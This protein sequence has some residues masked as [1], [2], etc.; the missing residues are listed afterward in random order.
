MLVKLL[1]Y[2]EIKLKP[3][4]AFQ[5]KK[6]W[7]KISLGFGIVNTENYIYFFLKK[8]SIKLRIILYKCKDFN[9][10]KSCQEKFNLWDFV[11]WFLTCLSNGSVWCNFNTVAGASDVHGA[12]IKAVHYQTNGEADCYMAMERWLICTQ[13]VLLGR[14]PNSTAA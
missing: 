8:K 13:T 9:C 7:P 11:M 12:T 3:L 2:T 4:G 10:V 5:V 14:L 6:C 1:S